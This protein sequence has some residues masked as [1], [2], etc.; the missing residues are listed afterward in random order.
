MV[1]PVR[2]LVTPPAV[3]SAFF[4]TAA[5]GGREAAGAAQVVDRT[6]LCTL[7]PSYL[8]RGEKEFDLVAGRREFWPATATYAARTYPAFARVDTGIDGP[9]SVLVAAIAFRHPDWG[10]GRGPAGRACSSARR[11]AA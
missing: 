10:A 8:A 3:A 7:A 9:T 6:V 5:S 4:A 1:K 11:A 2:A